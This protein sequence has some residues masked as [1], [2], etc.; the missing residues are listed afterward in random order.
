MDA[1]KHLA[2]VRGRTPFSWRRC[3]LDTLLTT[4]AVGGVT[5][6]LA[7]G[8]LYPRIPNI[9]IVYLLVVLPFAITRGRYAAILASVLAFLAFDFFLVP[10]YYTF[11]M[12]HIEEW[13]AL[14]IFL[15]DAFVTQYLAGAMRQ[16]A[17]E[18]SRREQETRVLYH[19]VSVTN[20]AKKPSDQLQA[21]NQAIVTVLA[22][23][24]VQACT[25]LQP[26]SGGVLQTQ[27]FA[28]LVPLSSEQPVEKPGTIRGTKAGWKLSL[29][30]KTKEEEHADQ[31]SR[32]LVPL[33]QGMRLIGV[34]QLDVL[35][36]PRPLLREEQLQEVH[37][38]TP[39]P[40]SFFWAFLG[41]VAAL[42]ERAQLQEENLRLEVLQRTDTLRAA[43]LSSVSHD[44][45]TPLTGIKAAASALLQDEIQWS[46]EA[47]RS[48][49]QS[50]EREADRLNRL[51]TNLLDMSRI[52]EGALKPEK[53][54]YSLNVLIQDVLERFSPA[55]EGRALHLHLPDD[56]LLVELDY[57]QIDQVLTN[58]L[59][60][61]LKYTPAISPI[62]VKAW[63]EDGQVTFQVADRGPG[64][65]AAHLKQVFDKFY[66]VLHGSPANNPS[67]GSGLGLAVCKG[68]VEAHGGRI[69]AEEHEGGGLLVSATLPVG[70]TA[71]M[72]T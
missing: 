72:P 12:Y 21:L 51:V 58:L 38:N 23:W 26:D 29:K 3:L 53:D 1:R 66:R 63:L 42:L 7:L 62:E 30:G 28:H 13:I 2:P 11:V 14:F 8:H 45:R 31:R 4:G 32:H 16:R 61:A 9:S 10:P 67:P 20:D 46:V 41:Q 48:F 25:I 37:A 64:I 18:A 15:G 40:S 24:G 56:L 57:L 60:N 47:Q 65:P 5:A 6:I 33:K 17:E 69:W 43:L 50:I 68:L 34:L 27:A 59:E 22:S 71:R 44:L 35:G 19:L 39:E 49:L 54:W 36:D 70:E 52:E 55:L